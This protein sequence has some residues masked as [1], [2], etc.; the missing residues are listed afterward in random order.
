[1][2]A[3]KYKALRVGDRVWLHKLKQDPMFFRKEL[4][5]KES[6]LESQL[7]QYLCETEVVKTGN[8]YF[9]VTKP[10]SRS[11]AVL[12]FSIFT[13][14]ECS[15]DGFNQYLLFL[16]NKEGIDF[17]FC[18]RFSIA[19]TNAVNNQFGLTKSGMDRAK[20]ETICSALGIMKPRTTQIKVIIDGGRV[21]AV[22]KD[23]DI[24]LEVEI[25]D[26]DP[27]CED[28]ETCS[29]RANQLTADETYIDQPFFYTSKTT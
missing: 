16:S 24:P 17:L 28:Y 5:E 12:R 11:D 7:A 1:M 8:R 27:D 10:G 9:Y 3:S 19:I 15:P 25:V 23:R 20:I 13:G 22:L 4:P 14:E 18:K 29:A 21:D 26:P 6:E 2:S